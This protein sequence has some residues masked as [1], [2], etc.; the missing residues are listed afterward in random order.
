MV[1]GRR[2]ESKQLELSTRDLKPG[3]PSRSP[4]PPAAHSAFPRPP[5]LQPSCQRSCLH[6]IW[7]Q[8]LSCPLLSATCLL[9]II[10]AQGLMLEASP[11]PCAEVTPGA[12]G[13]GS[14][15]E[16][17]EQ[18]SGSVICSCRSAGWPWEETSETP[19]ISSPHC[20]GPGERVPEPAL[21]SPAN[22]HSQS[23][24]HQGCSP[25]RRSHWTC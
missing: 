18:G 25:V 12:W 16:K 7:H 1:L 11:Q 2:Q 19:C 10:T 22:S 13:W 20:R 24:T 14:A 21:L 9:S 15:C 5:L 17:D 3:T 8:P 23:H 6:L 4:H